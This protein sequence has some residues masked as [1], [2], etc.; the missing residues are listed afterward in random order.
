MIKL[1]TDSTAYL[2][3]ALIG[4]YPIH[5]V[6]LSVLIDETIFIETETENKVFYTHMAQSKAFP[7]SAQPSLGVMMKAFEE[8]VAEGDEVIGIFLSS[9]MSGTYQT[10]CMVKTQLLEKY[11]SAHIELVDSR[12]NC[13][14]LG[15]CVLYGAEL[16]AQ[17]MPMKSVAQAMRSYV[18][19]S[20]FI[21]LPETLDYLKMG[22][23]IGGAQA[24]V[25]NIFQILPILTV[26]EGCTEVL[27]K[28]RTK[29]KA[30]ETLLQI[31][32]DDMA[33]YGFKNVVVHHI[34]AYEEGLALAQ[35]L[36]SALGVQVPVVDIGPVIGTHVGPGAIGIA[37]DLQKPFT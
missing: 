12:T 33:K 23:R 34:E 37:Y 9:E 8:A 21:F 20:R 36:L 26:K 15:F 27:Q 1:I 4:D 35:R 13:M 18:N 6:S 16:A 3:K 32:L 25:G 7:K 19:Q 11:P 28:V 31:A 10:A 24:I 17:G 29:K 14:Q 22:G 5:I 30:V 2:P